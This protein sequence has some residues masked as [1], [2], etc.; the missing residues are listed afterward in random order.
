PGPR[1]NARGPESA[2]AGTGSRPGIRA[3]DSSPPSSTR[4]GARASDSSPPSS[5]RQGARNADSPTMSGARSGARVLDSPTMSGARS[6]V[7]AALPTQPVMR[8]AKRRSVLSLVLLTLGGLALGA[9]GTYLILRF[10]RPSVTAAPV[11]PGKP[12]PARQAPPSRN[13]G[14]KAATAPAEGAPAVAAPVGDCPSGM[15][16]VTGGAFKL[17]TPANDAMSFPN[18]RALTSVQVPSFCVDEYEYPN[19][20]GASPKVNVAWEEAR[21]LCE[22]AGKRLCSEEEWEKACKGPGNARFPYGNEY[23]PAACNTEAPQ[24]ADRA[25]AASG[26][27]QRCRS[28]YGAVDMSGNVAEWTSTRFDATEDLTHKGGSFDRQDYTSR[29]SARKGAA[30]TER[31]ESVGFRCCADVRP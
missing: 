7:R 22:Q 1:A 3:S 2:P 26:T 16:L 21:T 18:E 20:A 5:T 12:V 14:E 8:K 9:G 4:Q 10:V 15:R 27:F 19:R 17:G 11:S 13:E 30:P 25:L 31:S 29:C 23:D 28:A 6:G 24:G